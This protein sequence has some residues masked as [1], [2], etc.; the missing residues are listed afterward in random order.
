MPFE[1]V[2]IPLYGASD[3]ERLTYHT[4]PH[5]NTPFEPQKLRCKACSAWEWHSRVLHGGGIYL[6][7]WHFVFNVAGMRACCSSIR[8]TVELGTPHPSI[9]PP[10]MTAYPSTT[11]TAA[12][13]HC[14]TNHASR[15]PLSNFPKFLPGRWVGLSLQHSH[16]TCDTCS[17][18]CNSD[19][20]P[21]PPM[22]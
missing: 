20:P 14:Q 1:I 6:V 21:C 7:S 19:R 8:K 5:P 3:I 16:T 17:L 12:T 4:Y 11:Q 22:R 2:Y 13:T 15:S 10:P 9:S 18:L